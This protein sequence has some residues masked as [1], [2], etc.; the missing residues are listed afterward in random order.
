MT[1]HDVL[2]TAEIAVGVALGIGIAFV[3]WLLLR[4]LA[5]RRWVRERRREAQHAIWSDR[6]W[7]EFKDLPEDEKERRKH[8]FAN[9]LRKSG[10][11]AKEFAK[12]WGLARGDSL[13]P[14]TALRLK[15]LD[16][17]PSALI[18]ESFGRNPFTNEDEVKD[19]LR[20]WLVEHAEHARLWRL[21][22]PQGFGYWAER[23]GLQAIR[24]IWP[25]EFPGPPTHEGIT[26]DLRGPKGK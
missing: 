7:R 20:R 23:L 21:A 25:E 8:E 18:A 24:S 3:G 1:F 17:L 13:D 22:N 6:I 15:A 12:I 4:G 11:T 26:T 19:S 10:E 14:Q 9:E 2:F 5:E 16:T